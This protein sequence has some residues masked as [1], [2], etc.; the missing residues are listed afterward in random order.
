MSLALAISVGVHGAV[1]LLM[2]LGGRFSW[3]SPPIPIEVTPLHRTVK[4]TAPEER[5]GDPKSTEKPKPIERPAVSDGHARVSKPKPPPGPPPPP[6]TADLK[7]FAPDD[8]N[9]VVLLRSDKLRKSPHRESIEA[10]L[11]A[12]PDYATLLGGTGLTPI[13]DFDALLIATANPRDVTATFLAAR[14]QESEKIRALGGRPLHPGD[15]RVFRFLQPGLAVL[16]QPDNAS[17]LDGAQA[18]DAGTPKEDP[19]VKWLKQLEQFDKVAAAENGPAVLVTLS[20]APALLRFG[21]GLPT[22]ETL[23]LAVTA[24][25]SPALRLKAVFANEA[26]AQKLEQAWP[27]ILR[28]FRTATALLGLSTALDGLRV[29]RKEAALEIEGRVPEAQMRLALSWVRAL[30]PTP[31]ALDAD[32]GSP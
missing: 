10:L 17:K 21:D 4:A 22:P 8:A 29:T 30:L 27:E 14:Y 15:P 6:A 11:S 2:V 12:L 25:A 19:R 3:P 9:L 32:G 24:E 7:P 5:R 20:D 16:A 26:D 28:R 13:D 1:L 18:L 31:M 23:A